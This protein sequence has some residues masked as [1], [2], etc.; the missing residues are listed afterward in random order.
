MKK[1]F[2]LIF[3]LSFSLQL[4]FAQNKGTASAGPIPKLKLEKKSYS[5]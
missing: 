3:A 4:I 5:G 1:I 2:I